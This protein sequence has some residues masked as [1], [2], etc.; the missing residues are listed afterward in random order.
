MSDYLDQ[1]NERAF[2]SKILRAV[3]KNEMQSDVFWTEDLEFFVN[4]NDLFGWACADGEP[5]ETEADVALLDRSCQ[6]S[7]FNGPALYCCR[8]RKM[9]PQGAFYK[10]LKPEDVDLFNACGP[11]REACLG[12]PVASGPKD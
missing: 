7:K 10:Y 6:D 11:Y 1:I 3:A 4:C 8:R 2:I 12:N 9:R 5:I